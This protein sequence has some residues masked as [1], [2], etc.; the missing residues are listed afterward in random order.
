M[1]L[2]RFEGEDFTIRLIHKRHS[3][4]VQLKINETQETSIFGFEDVYSKGMEM[5]RGAGNG[6]QGGC[7]IV[8]A[9]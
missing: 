4:Y 1:G 5:A 6:T 8:C 3:L 2:G 9:V 7:G